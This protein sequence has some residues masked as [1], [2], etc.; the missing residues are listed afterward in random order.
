M[1]MHRKYLAENPCST[2]LYVT[3]TRLRQSKIWGLYKNVL[4]S[5]QKPV[6]VRKKYRRNRR[7]GWTVSNN[8]RRIRRNSQPVPLKFLL[9]KWS[10]FSLFWLYQDTVYCQDEIYTELMQTV[11]LARKKSVL[12]LDVNVIKL[13][14]TVYLFHYDFS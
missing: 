12:I 4:S 14:T 2:V 6:L 13:T 9:M 11:K 5:S 10:F 3:F 7:R 1:H 8:E